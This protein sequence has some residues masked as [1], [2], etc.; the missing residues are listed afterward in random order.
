MKCP[1]S[2]TDADL[3]CSQ[4]NPPTFCRDRPSD[5][6]FV[7]EVPLNKSVQIS[8]CF[9]FR[10]TNVKIEDHE[11]KVANCQKKMSSVCSVH[12]KNQRVNE[13]AQEPQYSNWDVLETYQFWIFLL[14]M[15][16]MWDAMAIVTSVGDTICFT[17]LGKKNII[18]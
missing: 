5:F 8:N 7:S 17:L 11:Q 14:L 15:T 13:I 2:P 10:V 16:I 1:F 6:E 12:C 9:Y 18:I 3:L 4:W